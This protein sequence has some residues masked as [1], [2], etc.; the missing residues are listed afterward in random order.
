MGSSGAGETTLMD[1]QA[2]R[3]DSGR[4][5]GSIMVSFALYLLFCVPTNEA[6]R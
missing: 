3:K 1:S 2:Q 5:E 4:L 6:R